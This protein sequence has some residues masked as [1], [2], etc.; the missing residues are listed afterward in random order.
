MVEYSPLAASE[1]NLENKEETSLEQEFENYES[2]LRNFFQ[3]SRVQLQVW[4]NCSDE[5]GHAIKKKQLEQNSSRPC[6]K[7]APRWLGVNSLVQN[8]HDLSLLK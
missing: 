1:I 6:S 4:F 8:I 7:V 2:L 3:N 5:N